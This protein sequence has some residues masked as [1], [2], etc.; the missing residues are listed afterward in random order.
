MTKTLA[1]NVITQRVLPFGNGCV[2][3]LDHSDKFFTVTT[4]REQA[5]SITTE[6]SKNDKGLVVIHNKNGTVRAR[7]SITKA[8]ARKAS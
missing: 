1:R 4:S 6:L 7:K 2:V 3:K 5:I 8:T